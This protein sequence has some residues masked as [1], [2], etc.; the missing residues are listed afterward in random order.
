[1]GRKTPSTSY[2]TPILSDGTVQTRDGTEFGR[3]TFTLAAGTYF[4]PLGGADA[5]IQ[6]V[7]MQHDAACA[8]VA[9]IQDSNLPP[10]DV[11]D[12]STTAGH[13][14]SETPPTAYV[15]VAGATT[16]AAAGV[17]T[18]VAGNLGGAMWHVADTGARRTR[19]QIVVSTPGEFRFTANGKE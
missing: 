6:S 10:S 18:I 11:S 8:A 19:L 13:W 9:T 5:P 15:A 4:I 14:I 16:T 3:G 2:L 17:V 1:M 7:H 12:Y